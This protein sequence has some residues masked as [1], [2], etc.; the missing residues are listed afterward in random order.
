MAKAVRIIPDKITRIVGQTV[1]VLSWKI[2]C[3]SWRTV[4]AEVVKS[5]APTLVSPPVNP[6]ASINAYQNVR[7]IMIAT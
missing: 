2:V 4:V 5:D 3:R 6:F 1:S 7:T